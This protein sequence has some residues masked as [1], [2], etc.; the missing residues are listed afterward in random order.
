MANLG[1][2]IVNGV[3][4][5][6]GHLEASGTNSITGMD[7]S[8]LPLAGGTMTGNIYLGVISSESTSSKSNIIFGT[9][10][11]PY[12]SIRANSNK[13][14]IIASSPT[15]NLGGVIFKDTGTSSSWH[16]N[17]TNYT[18]LGLH[19][20]YWKTLYTNEAR[21]KTNLW[22]D[23]INTGK[24]GV[25]GVVGE[26]DYWFFGGGATA[27]DAGYVEISAG[28]NGN[29]PIYVRQYN[30][31]SPLSE[32][33]VIYRSATLLDASGNTTFPGKVTAANAEITGTLILSNQ[34]D[35]L[36]ESNE[37]VAL[38]VGDKTGTH[39]EIDSNE[40]MCKASA[41]SPNNLLLNIDGGSVIIGGDFEPNV[42]NTQT[43]GTSSMK[44][45]NVY[46]T[47]FT[48]NLSGTANVASKLGTANVG[49]ATRPIYLAAGVAT[50]CGQVASG[51]YKS[52]VPV[53]KDDGGMEIG[54]YVDFHT[55]TSTADYDARLSASSGNLTLIGNFKPSA[56]NKYTLG[57]SDLKWSNVY[58]TTFTGALSGNATTAS[59]AA[60]VT[61]ANSNPTSSTTY[62]AAFYNGDTTQKQ[63]MLA[64][65]GFDYITLEGTA[66]A[67]GYGILR[68]G[69][70]IA[71]GTAGNKHGRLR[72]QSSSTGYADLRMTTGTNG[73]TI[74]LPDAN[75]T[76]ALTS[77]NVASATKLAAAK[78]IKLDGIVSGSTTFDGSADKTI[79][80]TISGFSDIKEITKSMTLTTSWQ[81]TGILTN[82]IDTGSGTYIVQVY[83]NA[84]TASGYY[85]E[86]WSGIMSFCNITTNSTDSD[87]IVLHKNGHASNGNTVFLRTI[88]QGGST[89]YAK[90]QIADT[91][92]WTAAAN[93]RFR[94]RRLI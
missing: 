51:A 40:I 7:N 88:R 20:H 85:D 36:I 67:E 5:V 23:K 26:N 52:A 79:T 42:T 87:E 83:I 3:L 22:F 25:Q 76:L 34:T 75:G 10:S 11:A 44:W 47:T 33:G 17:E 37:N 89:S 39:L 13:A 68:L 80:T 71:S 56:T 14:L 90:L 19:N 18:D 12:I 64:N 4:R 46:A 35:V 30:A 28:D 48:G 62:R 38:I 65:N 45:S 21:I 63:A 86:Y 31:G 93:I 69:N 92:A 16:P 82:S 24:A 59:S 55:T 29:T 66:S 54:Q 2:T 1:N 50:A 49:S 73:R 8:K 81:D 61:I 70:T 27:T 57:T 41:S 60:K 77:S 43:L 32:Q 58:A 74:Y 15:D 84:G 72:L 91:H 6:N 78:T 9:E 53:I 94:F